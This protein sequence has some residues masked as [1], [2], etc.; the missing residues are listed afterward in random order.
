MGRAY[1]GYAALI[2]VVVVVDVVFLVVVA[3]VVVVVVVVWGW[4]ES[5]DEHRLNAQMVTAHDVVI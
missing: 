3:L 5:T 2:V 4:F 1:S